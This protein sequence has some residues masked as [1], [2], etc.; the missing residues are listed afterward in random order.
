MVAELN[1]L[2]TVFF[3]SMI[4]LNIVLFCSRDTFGL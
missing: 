3:K 2:E 4:H 1:Y